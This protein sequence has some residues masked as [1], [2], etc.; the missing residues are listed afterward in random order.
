MVSRLPLD[1]KN[2]SRK[3]AETQR[4]VGT[5]VDLQARGL[6]FTQAVLQPCHSKL[7]VVHG[8]STAVCPE[9][10]WTLLKRILKAC[11]LKPAL[12]KNASY[13]A[14]R[15]VLKQICAKGAQFGFVLRASPMSAGLW[16][17]GG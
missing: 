7:P 5:M 13:L 11:G 14:K 15:Y 17:C 16:R 12:R 9:I 2:S 1:E 10:V 4:K 8:Q 6:T 3:A